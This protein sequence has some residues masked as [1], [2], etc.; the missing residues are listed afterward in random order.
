VI[1]ALALRDP[2][3]FGVNVTLMVQLA[4]APTLVP[5]VLVWAKSP[6]LRPVKVTLLNE[7]AA[8][9]VLVNV[10]VNGELVTPTLVAGKFRL[11]GES[12]TYV[13]SPLSDTVCGLPVTLSETEIVPVLELGA[14]GV[15]VTV[16]VQ[17]RVGA[18]LAGQVL[19]WA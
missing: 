2:V 13:P 18:K 4:P 19:V 14:V 11:V 16:M 1:E 9:L 8:A 15:N 17:L 10:T 6:G 3:A 5:H 12:T 7:M